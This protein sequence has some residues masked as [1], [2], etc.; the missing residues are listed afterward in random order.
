MNLKDFSTNCFK[1][2]ATASG[3]LARS[4]VTYDPVRVATAA[5]YGTRSMKGRRS[6]TSTGTIPCQT[7]AEEFCNQSEFCNPR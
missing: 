4:R 5:G 7:A 3:A 6:G 1:S 2:S